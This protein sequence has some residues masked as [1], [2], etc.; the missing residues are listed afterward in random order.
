M[1]G[2]NQ[3]NFQLHRFIII[4]ILQTVL[5]GYFFWLTMYI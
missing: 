3:I 1:I 2:N 5:G 4:K